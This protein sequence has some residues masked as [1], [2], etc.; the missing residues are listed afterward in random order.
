MLKT[1]LLLL[2]HRPQLTP[3]IHSFTPTELLQQHALTRNATLA[4]QGLL[5]I[6]VGQA[7]GSLGTPTKQL[8]HSTHGIPLL[9]LLRAST[10]Y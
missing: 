5:N 9:D 7:I 8:L 2:R 3:M 6:Y 10:P 4:V 1:A